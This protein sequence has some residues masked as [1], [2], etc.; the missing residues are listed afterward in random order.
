[1]GSIINGRGSV[2]IRKSTVISQIDP[3]VQAFI[4]AANITDTTQ[5]SAITI[6]VSSL[7]SYGVWTKMKA[8]YPF[9]GG[10]PSSHKFNL[11]D[12]RDD[13]GAYRLTFGVGL[14]HSQNGINPNG[15][16]YA[17][18]YLNA[19]S[20]LTTANN[21]ISFYSRTNPTPINSVEMGA[22]DTFGYYS[23]NMRIRL[24]GFYGYTN[25]L[26]YTSGN[27]NNYAYTLSTN[28][29][30]RGHFIGNILSTTNRKTYKNGNVSGVNTSNISQ[31]LYN[32][33]IYIG[34]LNVNNSPAAYTNRE[35]A[36]AS[37][38]DG[39]TDTEASNFYTA[40]Q[41][42]QTSLSRNV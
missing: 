42:Y 27:I 30:A 23:P 29:D 12:P 39:L 38:G 15:S 8:I 3:D 22:S 35:C 33:F 41:A 36:F 13:N 25:T 5:K 20:V 1:M 34:A 19:S 2:G 7:K 40:V 9:V 26:M 21:H 32:G 28:T 37:I 14:T 10:T 24:D 6:L 4:T 18:T 16:G 17:N 11:K 31:S